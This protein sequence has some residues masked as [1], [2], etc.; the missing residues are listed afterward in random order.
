[1]SSAKRA[2][3]EMTKSFGHKDHLDKKENLNIQNMDD[4]L[5]DKK[6][7]NSMMNWW[8]METL[9]NLQFLFFYKTVK[10]SSS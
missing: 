9:Y 2:H 6:I 8:F 1:M 10:G 5:N 3:K 7:S 4:E